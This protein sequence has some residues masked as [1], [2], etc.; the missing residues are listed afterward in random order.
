MAN[1]PLSSSLQVQGPS[2]AL[3]HGVLYLAIRAVAEEAAV[4]TLWHER[5][6]LRVCYRAEREIK[7]DTHSQKPS[8]MAPRRAYLP[9]L[10]LWFVQDVVNPNCGRLS[11]T[12]QYRCTVLR[13]NIPYALLELSPA[14][15]SQPLP[16]LC[17]PPSARQG[18]IRVHPSDDEGAD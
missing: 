16:C 13:R 6:G 10:G 9:D 2:P 14:N 7:T 5:I 11:S 17:Y 15:R 12:T 8:G 18:R 3:Q 4:E 1:I